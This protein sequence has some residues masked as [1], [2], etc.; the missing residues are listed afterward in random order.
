MLKTKTTMQKIKVSAIEYHRNGVSGN[1]FHVVLFKSKKDGE[2]KESNFIATVFE[3]VGTVAVIC[4][5]LL[6]EISMLGGNAW[7]GDN[8]EP[9]LRKAIA[10]KN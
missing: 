6:P 9:E 10:A 1:G 4:L 8:F 2:R 3:E 7:R 5:D